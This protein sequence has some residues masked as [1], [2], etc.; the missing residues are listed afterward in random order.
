MEALVMNGADATLAAQREAE[1]EF[2]REILQQHEQI[3]R[4]GGIGLGFPLEGPLHTPLRNTIRCAILRGLPEAVIKTLQ[5]LVYFGPKTRAE[6]RA[7][8]LRGDNETKLLEAGLCGRGPTRICAVSGAPTPTMRAEPTLRMLSAAGAT[9]APPPPVS[10]A[11]ALLDFLSTV[12]GRLHERGMRNDGSSDLIHM[13]FYLKASIDGCG[14][15]EK[16]GPSRKSVTAVITEIQARAHSVDL[17]ADKHLGI[18]RWMRA[19]L[20][21]R[22]KL[23]RRIVFYP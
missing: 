18:L 8:G 21:T 3:L 16:N 6:R 11:R 22:A 7:L 5:V 13:I 17:V 19:Q 9:S 10:E 20:E 23:D 4:D 2:T 12:E 1:T 14:V 15:Q